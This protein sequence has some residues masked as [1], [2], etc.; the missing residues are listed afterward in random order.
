MEG[1]SVKVRISLREE[2]ASLIER[3]ASVGGRYASERGRYI[4]GGGG[5]VKVLRLE[6][7]GTS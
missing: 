3:A 7:E 4:P 2:G 1:T 6:E 5:D